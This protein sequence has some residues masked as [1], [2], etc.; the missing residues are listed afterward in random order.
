MSSSVNLLKASNTQGNKCSHHFP[1]FFIVFFSNVTERKCLH[2]WF[3]VL[4]SDVRPECLI[5]E[6]HFG[7]F[8]SKFHFI[9]LYI[10]PLLFKFL[11][12]MASF[13]IFFIFCFL[14]YILLDLL[15]SLFVLCFGLRICRLVLSISLTRC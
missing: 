4:Q 2:S 5:F 6:K 13:N 9:C 10:M 12:V 14:S 3:C 11:K 7:L 1:S 8:Y 15:V